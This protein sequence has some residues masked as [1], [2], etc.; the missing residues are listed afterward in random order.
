ML[1][2]ADDFEEPSQV[3]ENKSEQVKEA[4]KNE[5]ALPSRV[6]TNVRPQGAQNPRVPIPLSYQGNSAQASQAPAPS[7]SQMA[8]SRPQSDTTSDEFPKRK[9][10][11]STAPIPLKLLIIY[12][13]I[14]HA[15]SC[16]T[17]HVS[18]HA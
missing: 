18:L 1:N 3:V 5:P 17:I 16:C 6:E 2:V 13:L 7:P 11:V 8:V 9:G 4:T 15:L 14:S 12:A 10:T